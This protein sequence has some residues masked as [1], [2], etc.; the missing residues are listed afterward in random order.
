MEPN[1]HTYD[2]EIDNNFIYGHFLTLDYQFAPPHFH[3]SIELVYVEHGEISARIQDKDLTVTSGNVLLI[4]SN[5]M[6]SIFA[7][8]GIK[9]YVY[10]IPLSN[11]PDLA[12]KL[13]EFTFASVV[14]KDTDGY[15]LSLFKIAESYVKSYSAFYN[16]KKEKGE[17][18]TKLV[19][20]HSETILYSIIHLTGLIHKKKQPE[21]SIIIMEYIQN[22]C[23]EDINVES[24]SK[25]LGYTP[26]SLTRIFKQNTGLSV[27]DYIL[28]L[29]IHRAKDYI[30]DGKSN[31]EVSDLL[32]FNCTRSFIR[33]FKRIHNLTP[34]E[35]KVKLLPKITAAPGNEIDLDNI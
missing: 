19:S 24:V 4:G 29:K 26:Q 16:A 3:Q 7:D 34:G 10:T 18:Y 14:C 20:S 5:V 12:K 6:H 23:M 33:A 11:I 8:Y 13:S 1:N 15:F 28:Y 25:A 32:G 27:K 22:H 31:Q 21:S 30:L 35:Y 9:C 2:K 17:Y